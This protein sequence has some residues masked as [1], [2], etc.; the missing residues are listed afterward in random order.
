MTTFDIKSYLTENDPTMV[1]RELTLYRSLL[2]AIGTKGRAVYQRLRSDEAVVRVE[3][4]PE[5]SEADAKAFFAERFA[6][7]YRLHANT[8]VWSKN[9]ALVG[10]IRVF[11]DDDLIDCSF[12]RCKHIIL[13]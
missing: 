9:T 2:R 5:M 10:G 7:W 4:A 13:Q 1:L 6:E 12:A 3:H 11:I 8:I